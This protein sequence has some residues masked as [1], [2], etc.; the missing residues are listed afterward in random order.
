[1]KTNSSAPRRGVAAISSAL[2]IT[3]AVALLTACSS[4]STAPESPAPPTGDSVVATQTVPPPTSETQSTATTSA[5]GIAACTS[6][7]SKPSL[8][9]P[10]EPSV[11]G[12]ETFTLRYANISDS[13]C[14][15]EG[16]PG[17]TLT[18]P[19]LPGQG[20]E[21]QLGRSTIRPAESLVVDP[22]KSV[23]ADLTVLTTPPDSAGSW[24]PTQ[25]LTIAPD[26]TAVIALSWPPNTPVL[27]QDR[28]TH[29]GSYVGAFHPEG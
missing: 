7:T 23:V 19:D 29:P 9:S 25:L 2:S 8:D 18:G 4:N 13:P 28:A 17:A 5:Q 26:D 24:L 14:V 21:F 11:G 27:R 15:T 6:R 22:G 12:Q 3:T 16:Y 10:G 20:S 1:M